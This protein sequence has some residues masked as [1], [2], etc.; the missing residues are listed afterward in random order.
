MEMYIL[1]MAHP[2]RGPGELN[3][4]SLCLNFGLLSHCLFLL[5]DLE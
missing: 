4:S 1:K 5:L 3:R 2:E